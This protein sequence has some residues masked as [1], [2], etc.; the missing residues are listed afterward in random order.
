MKCYKDLKVWA[1]AMSL[2]EESYK[3]TKLLAKNEEYGL[4][5]QIR[6]AAVSIP[7]NIAEGHG[8]EHLGDYLHHLSVANGSL[9]E[10][11]THFLIANRLSFIKTEQ[12]EA[13][14]SLSSEVGRMLAGLVRSLKA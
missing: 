3:L 8:R 14:L 5:A 10:L 12:L 11:E 1:R 2:V 6:R 7:A 13:A 4:A 9:M